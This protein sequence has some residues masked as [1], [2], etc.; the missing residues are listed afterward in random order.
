[1]NY[2]VVAC[3]DRWEDD[4][5]YATQRNRFFAG[6][7]VEILAPGQKPFALEITDLRDG[8]GTSIETANH[9]MMQLSFACPTQVPPHTIIRKAVSEV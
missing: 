5:C 2:D 7:R 6:D 4:R 9:A 1:R 8:E 3:V